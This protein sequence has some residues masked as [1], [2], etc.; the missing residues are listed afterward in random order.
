MAFKGPFRPKPFRDSMIS[1]AWQGQ[2]VGGG[3][4]VGV[5]RSQRI[6]P[7]L[8]HHVRGHASA[9][10]VPPHLC[11]GLAERA[12]QLFLLLLSLALNHTAWEQRLKAR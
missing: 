6:A 2:R 9:R 7:L 1:G 4:V 11:H 8:P 10:C 5:R 3:Q 12:Q